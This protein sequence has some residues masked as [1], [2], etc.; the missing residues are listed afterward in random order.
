MKLMKSHIV[1]GGTVK[2]FKDNHNNIAKIA[3]NLMS[4][5]S[6]ERAAMRKLAEDLFAIAKAI[7][8]IASGG[9]PE[10]DEPLRVTL[11]ETM[12]DKERRRLDFLNKHKPTEIL[13]TGPFS[14]EYNYED[15]PG[16][17]AKP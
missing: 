16:P 2:T 10:V 7:D 12:N 9:K 1:P 3:I 4:E 8:E 6:S 15:Y 17:P 11:T 13:D 5:S 14:K